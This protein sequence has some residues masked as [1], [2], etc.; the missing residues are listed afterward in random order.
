MVGKPNKH[1]WKDA[2]R[3]WMWACDGGCEH[4]LT[5]RPV[6]SYKP[7]S[8]SKAK[9]NARKHL[10]K[11]HPDTDKYPEDLMYRIDEK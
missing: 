11:F 2:V 9:S 1:P 7:L 5:K 3:V 8:H 10:A 4:N 6:G